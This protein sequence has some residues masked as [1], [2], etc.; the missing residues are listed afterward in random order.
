MYGAICKHCGENE[1]E[2][3]GAF[4]VENPDKIS[5]SYKYSLLKCPGFEYSK[6]DMKKIERFAREHGL[7]IKWVLTLP[8]PM[9][10]DIEMAG[11]DYCSMN[12]LKK[13]EDPRNNFYIT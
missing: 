8:P 4:G 13:D 6:R 1:A 7:T 3:N 2:H 10:E 9:D 12:L 11:A 5:H